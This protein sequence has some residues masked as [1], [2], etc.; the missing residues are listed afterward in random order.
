MPFL[1]STDEQIRGTHNKWML[2]HAQLVAVYH[3]YFRNEP[4]DFPVQH[5]SKIAVKPKRKKWFMAYINN[6]LHYFTLFLQFI[7]I[8]SMLRL[9]Y[10]LN[11]LNK[12]KGGKCNKFVNI[13]KT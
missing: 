4:F 6:K 2:R 11:I 1:F 8:D 13:L 9:C 7:A 5:S 10:N 12:K 3:L